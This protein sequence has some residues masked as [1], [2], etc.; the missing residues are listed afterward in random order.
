MISLD[1]AEKALKNVYLGV[2]SEQL[3]L[4]TNA[5][6][7]KLQQTTADIFGKEIIKLA[8][9]GV[10]GGIGAGKET[11]AL[12]RAGGNNYAQ[13]RVE[14][15]NLFGT[16]EITDKAIRA[17]EGTSGAFVNL[18]NAEMEGLLRASKH[19]FGRMLYGNGT[20]KIAG[21]SFIDPNKV[22]GLTVGNHSALCEGLIIDI[23]AQDD[24][25][26]VK[27][28]RILK[29]D[30]DN[31]YVVLDKQPSAINPEWNTYMFVQNS[32]N[33]ELTGLGS[34]FDESS[35]LYGL[36]RADNEWL[37]P[38][39][40]VLGGTQISSAIVQAGLDET[41]LRFGSTPDIIISS[42]GLKRNMAEYLM[43]NRTNLDYMNLEG[44]Y[45][46]M[47]FSGIPWVSDKFVENGSVYLLN[48]ADFKLHQ[49]CD[50]RWLEGENGKVLHQ[51]PGKAAYSATLVKYADLICDRPCGQ[52]K[53]TGFNE[54]AIF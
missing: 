8:S 27:Q 17:S 13:F 4:G 22:V 31:H 19:N 16:I 7:A 9:Y 24:T 26:L 5:F 45:K 35:K 50:W 12:P 44:G 40:Y 21:I 53:F 2:V 48:T 11:D 46:A 54:T 47:S 32:Y 42:Y 34:I 43:L 20:G 10:N 39:R 3:N 36:E 28:A 41:D 14:L 51:V 38:Q 15:K 29:Y 37:K 30:R 6:Y 33:N 23:I 1:T 25:V 18:L 52:A 49:L